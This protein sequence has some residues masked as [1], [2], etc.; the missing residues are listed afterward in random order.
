MQGSRRTIL[1]ISPSFVRSE[2]TRFEYQVAQQEMLKRKHRIIPVLLDDISDCQ[3]SMDPNLKTILSSV[4]YL[5]WPGDSCP[6]KKVDKFWKRLQLSL[7]KKRSNSDTSKTSS[8]GNIAFDDIRLSDVSKKDSFS[9]GI[10]HSNQ[11]WYSEPDVDYDTI[12]E[13]DLDICRTMKNDIENTTDSRTN[14]GG[15]IKS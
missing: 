8:S 6:D 11:F 9:N 7:P 12:N 2:F 1:L 5:E 3:S 10:S 14:V 4:T 13:A 15:Q